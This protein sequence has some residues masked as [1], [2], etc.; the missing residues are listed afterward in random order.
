MF[1]LQVNSIL[2]VGHS[3]Y[4]QFNTIVKKDTSNTEIGDTKPA[5]WEPKSHRML[6]MTCTDGQQDIIAMEY[7]HLPCLREPFIPGF[8]V[9]F[10]VKYTQ[11]QC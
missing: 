1:L 6:K 3:C 7:E 4:S 2:D 11:L 10:F 8:K 5:P 9:C